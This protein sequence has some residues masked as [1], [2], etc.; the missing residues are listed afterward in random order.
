MADAMRIMRRMRTDA[1]TG[2]SLG[3]HLGKHLGNPQNVPSVVSS[4]IGNVSNLPM[5]KKA[6]Q[7][8]SSTGGL[9]GH[10]HHT[11]NAHSGNYRTHQVS[12]HDARKLTE[13]MGA[14]HGI[15]KSSKTAYGTR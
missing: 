3:N 10:I 8:S 1:S 11:H 15:V 13:T 4:M 2:E 9:A 6:N 14:S 5:V 7:M 12:H